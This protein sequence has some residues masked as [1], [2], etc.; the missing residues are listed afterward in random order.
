MMRSRFRLAVFD[1]DGTLVDTMN[2]KPRTAAGLFAERFGVDEDDAYREY[3]RFSGLGRRELFDSIAG[4]V[5]GRGLSDE[6]FLWLSSNY[7]RRN[8]EN[9][10]AG[11]LFEGVAEL[12]R[13]MSAAGV[14][15]A[16]SS[17][18]VQAEMDV[19]PRKVGLMPP[20]EFALGSERGFT[21]GPPHV[22]FLCE[23]L[24]IEPRHVV[25]VGDDVEDTRLFAEAQ[26]YV[27]AVGLCHPA[28]RLFEAGASEVIPRISDLRPVVLDGP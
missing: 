14:H 22:R 5:V 24:S 28:E 21:K 25:C 12:L 8:V 7:S 9:V 17:G 1:W 10:N 16:V 19:I 27:V 2:L 15:L 13:D 26:A 20:L 11:H 18:A 3:R 23:R 4:S 6:E